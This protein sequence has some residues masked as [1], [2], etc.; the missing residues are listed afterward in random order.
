MPNSFP[1]KYCVLIS[2]AVVLAETAPL[3]DAGLTPDSPFYFLKSWKEQIQ[4]FFTFGAENKANQYLHLAGVRLADYQKLVEKGKTEIAQK[5]LE[6]DRSQLNRALTKAEELKTN[7]EDVKN[8]TETIQQA[9]SKHLEILQQNL[10][11]VPEQARKGIENAIENSSKVLEGENGAQIANPASVNCE[12]QGGRVEIRKDSQGS[13]TG[14][15]IF[16]DNSECEEWAFFRNECKKGDK[17]PTITVLS[18]NGGE[19]WQV[20]QIY[21]IKWSSRGISSNENVRIGIW[22]AGNQEIAASDVIEITTINSGTYNW[23][24]PNTIKNGQYF[25]EISDIEIN[26]ARDQTDA[27]FNIK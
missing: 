19:M 9:I 1:P 13:E 24:I 17:K 4:L 25:V 26:E 22:P 7:G 2:S 16:S 5:T 11:K 12:N 3:P 21:Q 14:F 15:C 27:P 23:K 10:E 6:K 18:P 20:G 8:I